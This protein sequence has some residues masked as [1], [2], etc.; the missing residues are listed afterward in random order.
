[1]SRKVYGSVVKGDGIDLYTFKINQ[2]Y[3]ETTCIGYEG[4]I[5]LFN[6]ILASDRKVKGGGKMIK[7]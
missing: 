5:L 3:P 7:E 4:L 6:R 1:M 2:T